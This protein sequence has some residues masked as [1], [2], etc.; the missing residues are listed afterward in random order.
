[1]YSRAMMRSRPASSAPRKHNV[2]M[3]ML[4]VPM[5]DRDP[6]EASTQIAFHLRH[7]LA[8]EGLQI[9]DLDR[10]IR[11]YDK[12]ELMPV[13][14]NPLLEFCGVNLIS[15]RS[16]KLA[17]P[18]LTCNAIA[19]DVSEM[20]ACRPRSGAFGDHEASF[21]DD[22]SRARPQVLARQPRGHLAAPELC[23]GASAR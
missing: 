18:A 4:G 7:E 11:R 1:M 2:G 23:S 20:P 21:D 6:V 19:L 3:G 12:A 13:G 9:S 17:P 8:R 15:P 10:I 16:V 22:P 5:I 14:L